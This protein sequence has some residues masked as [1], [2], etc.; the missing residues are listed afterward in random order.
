LGEVD[1]VGHG[2][3]ADVVGVQVVTAV[4]AGG[5]LVYRGHIENRIRHRNSRASWV[6]QPLPEIIEQ[7]TAVTGRR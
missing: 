5:D 7:E 3:V 1:G 6:E 2:A 4:V